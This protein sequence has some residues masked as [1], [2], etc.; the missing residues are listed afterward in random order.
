[1]I[2]KPCMQIRW[3]K[4]ASRF[5]GETAPTSSLNGAMVASALKVLTCRLLLRPLGRLGYT[6]ILQRVAY[7]GLVRVEAP[8]SWNINRASFGNMCLVPTYINLY[9][10]QSKVC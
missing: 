3:L 10:Y 9:S 6:A 4:Q 1:M 2:E 7:P 5:L 8:L